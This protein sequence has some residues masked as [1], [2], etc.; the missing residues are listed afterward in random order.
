[1]SETVF[2]IKIKSKEEGDMLMNYFSH[3]ML[4]RYQQDMTWATSKPHIFW[5]L[6][7]YFPNNF[8]TLNILA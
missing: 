6:F 5:K 2:A 7:K 3:S 8:Y 1:M 4:L